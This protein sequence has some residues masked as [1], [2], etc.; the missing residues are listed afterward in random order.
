MVRWTALRSWFLVAALAVAAFCGCQ[1]SRIS[2]PSS[3]RMFIGADLRDADL[4]G[5]QLDRHQFDGANLAGADLR[6]V[7]TSGPYATDIPQD[8]SFRSAN[9]EGV[10]LQDARLQDA[11]FQG[12][13][14]R[15][16]DLRRT[17]LY[18]D[19]GR[20]ATNFSGAILD[21]ADFTGAL[22][23]KY[24]RWPDDFDPMERGAIFLGPGVDLSGLDLR[25]RRITG[26]DLRNCNLSGA[27]LM[28]ARLS[29]SNF[30][31]ADLRDADLSGAYLNGTDLQGA[32]LA[33]ANLRD[34]ILT[35]AEITMPPGPPGVLPADLRHVDLADADLT[36]ATYDSRTRWPEG[37][38]PQ[39][40]GA[41]LVEA[42]PASE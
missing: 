39:A 3:D 9:L 35:T 42:R 36:G 20:T 41:V 27:R 21:G 24:T 15:D 8:T 37:F 29:W 33:G 38:D 18:K 40:H 2:A 23:D 25:E 4:R 34:V 22:Y 5:Q 13:N 14:L 11:I 30:Q 26:V 19:G 31:D 32:N 16:A 1:A 17:V 7:D 10:D 28:N 6:E 12:A